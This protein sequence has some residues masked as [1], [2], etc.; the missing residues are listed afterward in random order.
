MREAAWAPLAVIAFY[1]IGLALHLYD[2]YPALDIPS[3]LA[4]GAAMTY[5]FRVA[6]RNSQKSLGEI[7]FPIQ[8]LLALTSTATVIILWEFYENILDFF[9]GANTVRGLLDTLQDMAMGLLGA[10]LFTI[11][12]RRK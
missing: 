5:F 7:P 12:Y 4:G 3:H 2:L 11:L 6:I 1:L 10:L 8:V 9:F